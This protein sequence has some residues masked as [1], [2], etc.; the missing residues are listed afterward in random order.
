MQGRLKNRHRVLAQ[1]LLGISR[2]SPLLHRMDALSNCWWEC[3]NVLS[4]ATSVHPQCAS[5][6]TRNFSGTEIYYKQEID[7]RQLTWSG[8]WMVGHG[9]L[10]KDLRCSSEA[11]RSTSGKRR[12]AEKVT[13]RKSP[14]CTPEY[15]THAVLG[16][17]GTTCQHLPRRDRLY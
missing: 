9:P 12:N 17:K 14:V 3:K 1:R 15:N 4:I 7:Q 13:Q 2:L 5:A 16:Q 10:P 8:K 6:L 11:Y